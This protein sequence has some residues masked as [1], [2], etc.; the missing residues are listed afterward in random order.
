MTPG[1]RPLRILFVHAAPCV[2]G[3]ARVAFA[4]ARALRAA[5]FE[6]GFAAE[7][8]GPIPELAGSGIEFHRLAL[9]DPEVHSKGVRY[10]LGLPLSTLRLMRWARRYDFLFV[11]HRQSGWPARLAGALTGSRYVF[12]A[13]SELGRRNRAPWATPLGGRV[14]AVAEHVKRN[15]VAN[16]GVP[17]DRVTVIPNAVQLPL[18]PPPP[19]SA[20]QGDDLD[21]DSDALVVACVAR[22]DPIKGHDTLLAA[23]A[24]IATRLPRAV[25]L[26]AG[27]GPLRQELQ[28]RCRQFGISNSVRFLGH[29]RDVSSVYSRADVVVL[30]SRSE[31]MPLSVLEAYAFGVPVVGTAIPGVAEVVEEGGSGLLVRPED[32][33]ELERALEALLLDPD[34]RR[35]MGKQGRAL[36]SGRYSP[37]R[38]AAALRTF[39]AAAAGQP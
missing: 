5:G 14:L 2:G 32:P 37:E 29:V 23:W 27:E 30:A 6:V 33:A 21:L 26:L 12:I 17:A 8:A 16:F 15:I 38:R 35:R 39:F 9:V 19:G 31:G 3:A 4:D 22:L 1:D 11:Q 7:A 20:S 13:H 28:E 24:G 36:A 25:L 34:R 10:A 18:A